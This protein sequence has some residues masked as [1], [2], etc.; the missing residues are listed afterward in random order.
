M[1]HRRVGFVTRRWMGAAM[2]ASS[3]RVMS[4]CLR[5]SGFI[6]CH[7]DPLGC[8]YSDTKSDARGMTS[9]SGSRGWKSRAAE[10]TAFKRNPIQFSWRPADSEEIWGTL[11]AMGHS[12]IVLFVQ[13]TVP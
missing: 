5:P 13:Q 12:E 4:E 8:L 11:R 7:L 9:H 10:R 1:L 6:S 3:D 2:Q